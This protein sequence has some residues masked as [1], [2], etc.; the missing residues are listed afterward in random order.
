MGLLGIFVISSLVYVAIDFKPTVDMAVNDG[1]VLHVR[2]RSEAE[3]EVY[4]SLPYKASFALSTGERYEMDLR[5]LGFS[6][7]SEKE[8][9]RLDAISTKSFWGKF[10]PF[11]DT[12]QNQLISVYPQRVFWRGSIEEALKDYPNLLKQEPETNH[13]YVDGAGTMLMSEPVSGYQVEAADFA[14]AARDIAKT[15]VFDNVALPSTPIAAEDQSAQLA[16]YPN[17]IQKLEFEIPVDY[18]SQHNVRTGF[19]RMQNIYIAA[20]E[21]VNISD[22]LGPLNAKS[23]YRAVVTKDGKKVY[24]AGVEQIIDTI[25]EVAFANM[26]VQSYK[27]KF[28]NIGKPGEGLTQLTVENTTGRNMVFSLAIRDGI[29]SV[30]LAAE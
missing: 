14:Q 20:G 27:G 3:V 28:I 25:K 26:T 6:Y 17:L 22:L 29:L 24:G 12:E 19:Y 2:S 8:L 16:A 10:G 30:V 9:D 21:T 23:G 4:K 11:F 18:E 15:G 13:L 7:F 5:Y 1:K